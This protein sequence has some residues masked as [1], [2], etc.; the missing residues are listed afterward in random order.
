MPGQRRPAVANWV[1]DETY[2]PQLAVDGETCDPQL[3][4]SDETHGPQLEI[5]DEIC[6]K[7]C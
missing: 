2:G 4:T 7:E 6:F 3:E 1:A 5:A